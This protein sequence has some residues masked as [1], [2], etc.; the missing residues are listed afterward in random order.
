MFSRNA[1]VGKGLATETWRRR[2]GRGVLLWRSRRPGSHPSGR[3]L[4][5]LVPHTGELGF[6]EAFAGAQQPAPVSPL[7]IGLA[8]APPPVLLGDPLPHLGDDLVR[9]ATR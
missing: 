9:R 1:F 3:R 7:R 5:A 6:G 2:A 4:P 8:A